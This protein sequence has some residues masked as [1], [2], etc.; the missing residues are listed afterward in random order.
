MNTIN[1]SEITLFTAEEINALPPME[2]S[3]EI[4]LIKTLEAA[5]KAAEE[6]K[7]EK[8]LG[9]DTETRP[10]F[11]KGEFHHVALLQLATKSRAYLF[12]LNKAPMLSLV[13]DILSDP[14]ILKVGVATRDDIKGLQKL[15]S[16][17]AM[18]FVDIAQEIAKVEKNKG[19]TH[20]LRALV[21][22][23]LGL[24]LS[25]G[26]KITNWEA[27][28]L[29]PSQIKYAAKDAVTGLLIY[30]KYQESKR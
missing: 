4:V 16:F 30:Q 21:A 9:F 20:G 23:Y 8:I 26:A 18:G 28:K 5:K 19:R 14:E 24:K 2:F 11:K 6:L 1:K 17:E 25:K 13:S 29:S 15:S 22:H 10:S 27:E 12:R 3:G 7:C